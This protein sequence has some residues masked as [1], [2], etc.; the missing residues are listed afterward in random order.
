[1]E[2]SSS[3]T[4][5]TTFSLGAGDGGDAGPHHEPHQEEVLLLILFVSQLL[6]VSLAWLW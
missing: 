2:L 5:S 3:V 4:T 6:F 1:M